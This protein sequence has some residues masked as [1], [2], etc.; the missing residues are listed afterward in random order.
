MAR[1]F[2]FF[3]ILLGGD[4]GCAEVCPVTAVIGFSVKRCLL[5]LVFGADF[6]SHCTVEA[7]CA[8]RCF[9]SAAGLKLMI[10]YFLNAV[11]DGRG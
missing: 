1:N 8:R 5:V 4:L 7:V 10:P 11:W 9:G 2:Y 3:E 6:V